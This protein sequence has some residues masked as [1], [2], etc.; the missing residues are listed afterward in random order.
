MLESNQ[1]LAVDIFIYAENR[2]FNYI[3]IYLIV[4]NECIEN[5]VLFRFVCIHVSMTHLYI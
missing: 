1:T 5:G 2:T 3:D 4:F